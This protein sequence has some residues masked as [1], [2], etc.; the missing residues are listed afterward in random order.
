M[1]MA[2]FGGT[3]KGPASVGFRGNFGLSG[4]SSAL[5]LWIREQAGLRS[6]RSVGRSQQ[7]PS[8]QDP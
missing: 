5:C 2:A 4:S 8:W 7:A 6:K 3:Q 1:P